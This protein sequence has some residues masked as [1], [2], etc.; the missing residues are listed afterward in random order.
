MSKPQE[1]ILTVENVNKSF[2]GFKAISDLNFYMDK[3][4]LRTII[5]PNGAGK[6]TFL[7]LITGKIKCKTRFIY[8]YSSRRWPT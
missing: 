3:G 2:E 6:S 4:E 5:G 7:D 8:D 1:F